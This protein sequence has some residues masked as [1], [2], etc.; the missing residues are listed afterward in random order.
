MTAPPIPSKCAGPTGAG[1]DP[2]PCIEPGSLPRCQLCP[3][4]PNYWLRTEPVPARE[5]VRA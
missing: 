4:S 3:E 5:G 2:N 1:V